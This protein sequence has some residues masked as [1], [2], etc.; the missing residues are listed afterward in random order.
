M[1]KSRDTSVRRVRVALLVRAPVRARLVY[2]SLL[3]RGDSP[4][5]AKGATMNYQSVFCLIDRSLAY[6]QGGAL[7]L[8]KTAR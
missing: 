8:L 5:L 1:R 6:I 2:Q 3:A 4:A 7:Q